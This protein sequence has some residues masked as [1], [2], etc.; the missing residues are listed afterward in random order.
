M[1]PALGFGLGLRSPHYDEILESK[2]KLGWFEIISE[3]FMNA[4]AGYQEF[5]SDLRRDYPLVIHGVSLSIG[6]TD[7]LKIEYL[8]KL[9]ALADRLE[10]AWVSDHLCFTGVAGKNTHDLLP[11]PYTAEA[12]EH[13]VP[14]ILQ[15]QE[16]LGRPL[17]LEN[18]STYLE[19]NG[20]TISEPELLA[21]LHHRTGCGILLDVNNVYVSSFNHGWDA[22][23]Y[24]D[25]IPAS[26]IVQ[27][28]LAGHTDQHTHLIDT[29]SAAVADPVW[30]LFRY[31]LETKGLRSTM[32]E[33]DE[34]IPEFAVVMAELEKAK[35]LAEE[36]A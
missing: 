30:E 26:A 3:N 19:F 12:I 22:K 28:H 14:R 13:L 23:K 8:Q 29:H 35:T 9:R 2:P 7:P 16:A 33:W 15:V 24:I 5:L 18:A 32:I 4:H 31:T 36:I 27:Y 34:E 21:E 11:I 25:A 20:T 6:S 17:V 1:L 10:V